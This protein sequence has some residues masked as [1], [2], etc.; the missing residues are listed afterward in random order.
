MIADQFGEVTKYLASKK[1]TKKFFKDFVDS[2]EF[3][4]FDKKV[5]EDY[6]QFTFP[7]KSYTTIRLTEEGK[8]EIKTYHP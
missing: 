7:D 2:L 6:V 1:S 8:I 5:F 4:Q 3:L